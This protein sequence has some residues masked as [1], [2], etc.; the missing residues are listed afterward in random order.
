MA[1][2]PTNPD[3]STPISDDSSENET[4]ENIDFPMPEGF[5]PP[6]GTK[7]G[8]EFEALAT[9]KIDEDG[10]LCLLKIDG[11][12]VKPESEENESKE[13]DEDKDQSAVDSMKSNLPSTGIPAGFSL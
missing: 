5:E 10:D 6:K 4:E 1:D 12:D 9:L 2:S 13:G 7:P 11:A 8:Q 3:D